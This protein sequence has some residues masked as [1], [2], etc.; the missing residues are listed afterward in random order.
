MRKKLL[1]ISLALLMI[2]QILLP[3]NISA[4]EAGKADL[5]NVKVENMDRENYLKLSPKDYLESIEVAST[6]GRN[7]IH[8]ALSPAGKAKHKKGAVSN[9]LLILTQPLFYLY[10]AA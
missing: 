7:T 9:D 5:Q 1:S 6:S 4:K 2:F 8:Y 10:I 3:T